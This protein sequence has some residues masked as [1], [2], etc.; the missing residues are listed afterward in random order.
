MNYNQT[1]NSCGKVRGGKHLPFQRSS[2][3]RPRELS[4]VLVPLPLR[5]GVQLDPGLLL[6]LLSSSG[7]GLQHHKHKGMKLQDSSF[8]ASVISKIQA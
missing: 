8:N 6:T 1:Q 2:P 7:T 3:L 5:P 4:F